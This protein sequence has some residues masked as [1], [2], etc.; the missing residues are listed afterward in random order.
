[1]HVP[2]S[3]YRSENCLLRFVST[4]RGGKDVLGL[5]QKQQKISCIVT[6]AIVLHRCYPS[7]SFFFNEIYTVYVKTKKSIYLNMHI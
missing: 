7:V 3:Y 5:E 2:C 1:M 6:K 4:Q